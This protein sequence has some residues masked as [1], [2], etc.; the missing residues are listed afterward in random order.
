MCHE[1]SE[2]FYKEELIWSL[3]EIVY[4]ENLIGILPHPQEG[5]YIRFP[6]AVDRTGIDLSPS[7]PGIHPD[8]WKALI[9]GLVFQLRLESASY[10]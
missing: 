3:C 10:S 1:M 5:I 7:N 4:L 6:Y 9:Y 8:Y 2:I